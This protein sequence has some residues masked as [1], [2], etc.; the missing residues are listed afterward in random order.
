MCSI[1]YTLLPLTKQT[2]VQASLNSYANNALN[3]RT[4]IRA[5]IPYA[6]SLAASG[7]NLRIFLKLNVAWNRLQAKRLPSHSPA[8]WSSIP[9]SC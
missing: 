8:S 7:L 4:L 9:T 2:P 6:K 1:T 3:W 5:A